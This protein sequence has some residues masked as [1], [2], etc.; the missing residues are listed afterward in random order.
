LIIT[1]PWEC[2]C[3]G[4]QNQDGYGDSCENHDSDEYPYENPEPE[5][6]PYCYVS[7]SA[8]TAAGVLWGES[9]SPAFDTDVIGWSYDVCSR[10]L[11]TIIFSDSL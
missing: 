1:Y 5:E 8:C 2:E 10:N 4:V 7:T 6:Y 3:L 11:K 9:S